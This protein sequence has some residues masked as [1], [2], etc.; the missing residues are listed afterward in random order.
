MIY[1]YQGKYPVIHPTVFIADN[2]TIVGDVVIAE[3]ASVWFGTV[4]RGDVHAIRIGA[5][6]NIQD[7]A[8]LHVTWE[9]YPLHIGADITIGHGA[10]L[11]GCTIK[12]G[13]L[14]GMG[15][16]VLDGAL[17][18]EGSFVAA[19]SLVKQHF[20]VPAG[21]LVGGVPAKVL[22][23][24]SAEERAGI[25]ESVQH[26]LYYVSEYRKHDDIGQGCPPEEF[27]LRQEQRT[28]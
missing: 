7:N 11:H 15:A 1:P 28:R 9:Q 24:L 16:T 27:F 21:T 13:C 2:A 20:V 10:I 22:R 5:R 17:V 14:I 25:R 6:T 26:Y 3:H 19:G 18:E 8:V 23:T 4:V 12:D